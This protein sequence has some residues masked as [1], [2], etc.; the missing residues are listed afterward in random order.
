MKLATSQLLSMLTQPIQLTLMARPAA[1]VA[2]SVR[3]H[4]A[5]QAEA[6]QQRR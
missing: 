3:L 2:T 6:I 1:F 4:L 5:P